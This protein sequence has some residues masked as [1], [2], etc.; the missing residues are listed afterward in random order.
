MRGQ[1][2]LSAN[3]F[4]S[5]KI[6]Q[7]PPDVSVQFLVERLDFLPNLVDLALEIERLVGELPVVRCVGEICK[8]VRAI[9][10]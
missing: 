5:I 7:L 4:R 8:Y 3:F 9:V 6:P 2:S 1:R 10:I